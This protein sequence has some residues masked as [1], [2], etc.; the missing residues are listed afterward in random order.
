M[1][2]FRHQIVP[3][4][5]P[6][7]A[8]TKALQAILRSRI[9]ILHAKIC[10]SAA[11]QR[12]CEAPNE[13]K[14][15]QQDEYHHRRPKSAHQPA[16]LKAILSSE[17]VILPRSPVAMPQRQLHPNPPNQSIPHRRHLPPDRPATAAVKTNKG[18]GENDDHRKTLARRARSPA[19]SEAA[20]SRRSLDRRGTM[21]GP[22]AGRRSFRFTFAEF[23]R[24][25]F[26]RH[27]SESRRGFAGFA[28]RTMQLTAREEWRSR[29]EGRALRRRKCARCH[30]Q[31]ISAPKLRS[32]RP[33]Q[34]GCSRS[35]GADKLPDRAGSRSGGAARRVNPARGHRHPSRQASGR[36]RYVN[37]QGRAGAQ[38][39]AV[40]AQPT[41]LT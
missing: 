8:K 24:D 3:V 37:P 36:I 26:R 38:R 25:F 6:C 11:Q 22:A 20:R 2:N 10:G 29:S 33:M 31:K 14:E 18:A 9:L 13:H 17:S 5:Y 32:G 23:Y 12:K 39:R 41:T 4:P 35:E 27:D 16:M 1:A 34:S 15:P 28:R 40:A 30:C 19:R 7:R 21:G